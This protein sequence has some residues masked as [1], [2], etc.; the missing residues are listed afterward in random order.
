MELNDLW[1][2]ILLWEIIDRSTSGIFKDIYLTNENLRSFQGLKP[3]LRCSPHHT[4][5]WPN[6]TDL[7]HKIN[8]RS[9]GLHCMKGPK[10]TSR[11]VNIGDNF[12]SI[13][14]EVQWCIL[15]SMS[16]SLSRYTW[17]KI[18]L[19]YL[20]PLFSFAPDYISGSKIPFPPIF[21]TYMPQQND[22]QITCGVFV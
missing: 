18:C 22:C 16:N 6:N 15:C 21:S 17:N 3:P 5:A 2:V 9:D 11:H 10:E 13:Q 4:T 8:R 14:G 20:F 7:C 19:F 12:M 1:R